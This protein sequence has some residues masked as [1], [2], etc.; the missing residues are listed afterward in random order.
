MDYE[1]HIINEAAGNGSIQSLHFDMLT[2]DKSDIGNSDL[3]LPLAYLADIF[4]FHYMPGGKVGYMNNHPGDLNEK[5]TNYVSFI[6]ALYYS[7]L[8]QS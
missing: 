3:H 5:I 4:K 1:I 8:C 6:I 7:L 2:H